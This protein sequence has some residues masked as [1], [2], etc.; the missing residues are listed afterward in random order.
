MKDREIMDLVDSTEIDFKEFQ[1]ID[2][3]FSELEKKRMFK[4]LTKSNKTS[5]IKKAAAAVIVMGLAVGV[6]GV[7]MPS[8]A[9]NMPVVSSIFKFLGINEGYEKIIDKYGVSKES[10]GIKLTINDVVYDGYKLVASY[11]I[12]GN[13]AFD[14]KPGLGAIKKEK[15]G[16]TVGLDALVELGDKKSIP[17]VDSRYG[18][19]K[20][21][22][23]KVYSGAIVFTISSD[24]FYSDKELKE[25]G[26]RN[27]VKIR[28]EKYIDAARIPDKFNFNL[29]IKGLNEANSD[30]DLKKNIDGEWKFNLDVECKKAKSN[31]KEISV[32]KNFSDIL[33]NSSLSKIVVTPISVYLERT[34]AELKEGWFVDYIL[35]NDKGERLNPEDIDYEKQAVS[36]GKLEN[37]LNN[38]KYIKAIPYVYF[39]NRQ[40]QGINLNKTGETKVPIG[41]NKYLTITKLEEKAGKTYIYY[42]SDDFIDGFLPFFFKD[43]SE[44]MYMRNMDE[45]VIAPSG[46]EGFEV[47]DEPLLSKNLKVINNTVIYYD[48]EFTIDLK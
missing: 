41:S 16:E 38:T 26:V 8:Y 34:D 18:E 24:S 42:K 22:D 19:F 13:K 10:S 43:D 20:D 47:Y 45:S 25:M 40:N 31:I 33:P 1:N 29:D 4:N 37:S 27:V 32:N 44:N 9:K 46:K 11:T 2:I 7:T 12:E 14:E 36:T 23:K 39:Q 35:L 15:G 28:N 6:F 5:Y 3:S 30:G 21:K 48:K 17:M